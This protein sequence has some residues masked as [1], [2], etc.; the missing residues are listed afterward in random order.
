M[1]MTFSSLSSNH[2]RFAL[3]CTLLAGLAACGGGGDALTGI[4]SLGA[5]FQQAFA[6]GPTDAPLDV[7]N[8]GLTLDVTAEPF[9]L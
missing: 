1:Q 6:Q 9:A 8:A 7:T 2:T 5:V 4:E 3:L